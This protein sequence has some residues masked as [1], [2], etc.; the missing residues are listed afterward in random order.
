MAPGCGSSPEELSRNLIPDGLIGI[1]GTDSTAYLVYNE[2]FRGVEIHVQGDEA[3]SW[4]YDVDGGGFW[5]TTAPGSTILAAHRFGP[6]D[7][8]T[9]SGS[10]VATASGVKRLDNETTLSGDSAAT[11]QVLFAAAPS[12]YKSLV[13]SG[14]ASF[15]SNTTDTTGTVDVFGGE[16]AA[17][18]IAYGVERQSSVTIGKLQ[19][20]HGTW[21]P[22][23][24]GAY[25]A[26]VI[27]QDDLAEYWSVDSLT[28][29]MIPSG[30][31]RG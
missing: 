16:D 31:E 5:K 3:A 28:L 26:V 15:G 30:V 8:A 1:N 24:G 25:V 17:A 18:A 27:T 11:A 29:Q 6:L 13:Q 12:G 2:R 14:N 9:A 23:V 4:F 10:L 21:H 7:S 19:T 20:N 22:R